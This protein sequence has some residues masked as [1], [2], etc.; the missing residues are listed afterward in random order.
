MI[1]WLGGTALAHYL[2]E[3]E[4]TIPAIQSVH[5]VGIVVLFT[6]ML[7]LD[8]RLFGIAGRDWSLAQ[9]GRLAM[10]VLFPVLAV[11]IVTGM[12]MIFAEPER[13]LGSP[14]FWTKMALV[15]LATLLTWWIG[16]Q[17]AVEPAHFDT[18]PGLTRAL[19]L[20]LALCWLA[21]VFAGRWIAYF[22]VM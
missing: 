19:G 6:A 7:I 9:V 1:E 2:Q 21:I 13:E 8:L 16:R 22:D 3:T 17:L 15:V 18:R 5:I 20:I 14:V 12:L 11:M 10:P 4:W